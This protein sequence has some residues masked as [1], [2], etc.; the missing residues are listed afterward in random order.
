MGENRFRFCKSKDLIDEY[1][2]YYAPVLMGSTAKGMFAMPALTEM[3]HRKALQIIETCQVGEDLR[4]RAK[5][6]G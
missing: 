6:R 4:V 3:A 5:P 2:L 1:V